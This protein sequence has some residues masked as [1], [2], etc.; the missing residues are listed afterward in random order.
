MPIPRTTELLL[1]CRPQFLVLTGA[2]SSRPDLSHFVAHISKEVGVMICGQ[3]LVVSDCQTV[4]GW[5]LTY[6]QCYM[7]V[8]T[9]I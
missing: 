8:D 1:C 2:P 6:I 5:K 4:S 9:C 7:C 3:V